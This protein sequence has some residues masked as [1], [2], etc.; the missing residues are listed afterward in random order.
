MAKYSVRHSKH[1]SLVYIS[2][3]GYESFEALQRPE[4]GTFELNIDPSTNRPKNNALTE[5]HKN[6]DPNDHPLV[7]QA[8]KVLADNGINPLQGTGT[9][10]G[11]KLEYRD[12]ASNAPVQ[13]QTADEVKKGN[14]SPSEAELEKTD[15]QTKDKKE[16]NKQDD[17][18][19]TPVTPAPLQNKAP[20]QNKQETAKT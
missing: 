17:K 9:K 8:K 14:V 6:L 4:I 1:D 10:L 5:A 3:A 13:G 16:D 11:V 12:Q 20:E 18:K 19:E 15:K 2:L 7:A